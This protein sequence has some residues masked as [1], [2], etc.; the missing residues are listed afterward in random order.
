M[1]QEYKRIVNQLEELF[2]IFNTKHIL[3]GELIMNYL[4]NYMIVI[5]NKHVLSGYLDPNKEYEFLGLTDKEKLVCQWASENFY[6][7]TNTFEF[8]S[9]DK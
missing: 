8:R 3:T 7:S 1:R 9:I 4:E 2:Q 5:D 6:L